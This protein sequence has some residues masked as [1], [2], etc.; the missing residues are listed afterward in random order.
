MLLTDSRHTLSKVLDAIR[1]AVQVL[2]ELRPVLSELRQKKDVAVFITEGRFHT[3]V[4]PSISHYRGLCRTYSD[5]I[6]VIRLAP[7]ADDG[8][9]IHELIHAAGYDDSVAYPIGDYL[10]WVSTE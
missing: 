2:P 5:A 1:W 3:T 9:I 8:T 4:P 7:G 10:R 6:K